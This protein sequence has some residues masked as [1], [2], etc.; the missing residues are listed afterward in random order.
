[1][2]GRELASW[3]NSVRGLWTLPDI[4]NLFD[5]QGLAY[6]L[7]SFSQIEAALFVAKIGGLSNHKSDI[8]LSNRM[9]QALDT[10]EIFFKNH[11]FPNSLS[12][13]RIA[14]HQW[15][16]PLVDN[17]SA[18]EIA[19]RIQ[20]D[21]IT[22]LEKK[23]FL[24]VDDQRG[25]VV[26]KNSLFGEPVKEAFGSASEDIKEA[27][28]CLAAECNTA[29]V[30]HLMRAAEVAL[31]ALAKDRDVV[32]KEKPLELKD[33]GEILGALEGKVKDLRLGESKRWIKPEI[34]EVQIRFYNEVLQE[35]RG[36]NEAWRRHLS[37]VRGGSLYDRDYAMSVYKHVRIFMQKLAGKISEDK[38][39]PEFWKE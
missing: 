6:V 19:H 35:L 1:V 8:N 37:H 31:R 5:V 26:D 13:T 22:D 28:N 12:S 30:F 21:I 10:A 4:M 39:T 18:L 16:R 7:H 9:T 36:F 15:N 29:A 17:S 38:I 20:V 11:N 27:G 34:R 24:K 33:W 25:E 23:V 3:D 14:K 2:R 32:F